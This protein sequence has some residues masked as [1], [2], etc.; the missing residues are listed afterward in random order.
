MD[1]GLLSNLCINLEDKDL[2]Q[3]KIFER[4]NSVQK[5]C[6]GLAEYKDQYEAYH[7]MLFKYTQE[8]LTI[9]KGIDAPSIAASIQKAF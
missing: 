4:L 1:T 7:N 3:E 8:I 2:K 6:S 9:L 5:V